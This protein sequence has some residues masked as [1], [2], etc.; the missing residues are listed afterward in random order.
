[1]SS[2]HQSS[3]LVI[4]ISPNPN[5][6]HAISEEDLILG[7]HDSF[8]VNVFEHIKMATTTTLDKNNNLNCNT[9]NNN[10]KK[11]TMMTKHRETER[12]RRQGM[13]TLYAS[14]RSL[15]PLE[16]M[17]GKRSL[18]DNITQAINYI[19]HLENKINELG[20]KRDEL[21]KLS[22][23]STCD[24]HEHGISSG[25]PSSSCSSSLITLNPFSGGIEIV[26]TSS[27]GE[28]S[29]ALSMVLNVLL[30]EGL[31]VNNY[32]SATIN[33][34]LHHTIHTGQVSNLETI[35]LSALEKKLNYVISAS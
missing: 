34:R 29:L 5:K 30:E 24:D 1:M 32:I 4:Q 28:G 8:H 21:K 17:K 7:R 19:K 22:N 12:L 23:S 20:T 11:K 18:S 35:N 15:L 26:I 13:A 3:E 31:S 25:S 9:D 10:I 16:L 33:D 2:L 6:K 27:S 14:L